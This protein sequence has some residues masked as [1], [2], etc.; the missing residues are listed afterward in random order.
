[1][2][3]FR[4]TTFDQGVPCSCEQLTSSQILLCEL[5]L[6]GRKSNPIILTHYLGRLVSDYHEHFL[7]QFLQVPFCKFPKNASN[8]VVSL[9]IKDSLKA[10][11]HRAKE[12]I[13]LD[14]CHLFLDSF[15]LFFDRFHVFS[16]FRLM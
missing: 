14:V 7:Q 10:H 8:V 16:R 9:L 1:M 11:S 13:L 2:D 5:A 12:K 4:L 3:V 6:S 15:Q